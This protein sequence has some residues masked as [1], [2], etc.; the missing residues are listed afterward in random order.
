MCLIAGLVRVLDSATAGNHF[1]GISQCA[2]RNA[3]M[4]I[5]GAS[6][7]MWYRIL[8]FEI[9]HELLNKHLLFKLLGQCIMICFGRK[10]NNGI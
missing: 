7:Q 10:L 9:F 4:L 8:L 6:T 1:S 2:L 3:T 5:Q